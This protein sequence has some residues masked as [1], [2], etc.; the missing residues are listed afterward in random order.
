LGGSAADPWGDS[1]FARE[2]NPVATVASDWDVASVDFTYDQNAAWPVAAAVSGPAGADPTFS[3]VLT[4]NGQPTT[5]RR[6]GCS[7][8]KAWRAEGT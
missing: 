1:E 7:L 4:Q 5:R 2:W 3:G 8:R 6:P